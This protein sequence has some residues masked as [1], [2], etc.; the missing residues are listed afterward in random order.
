MLPLLIASVLSEKIK[1]RYTYKAQFTVSFRSME[2]D[3]EDKFS[4]VYERIAAALNKEPKS[5]LIRYKGEIPHRCRTIRQAGVLE[6]T[7]LLVSDAFE[8]GGWKPGVVAKKP[9]IYVYP[10]EPT[11]VKI[12]VQP[13]GEFLAVYP[14]FTDK[15]KNEWLV[16][17]EPGGKLTVDGRKYTSLFWEADTKQFFKPTFEEGFIVESKNA[18]HFLEKKL[19]FMGLTDLEANEFITFW[20]PVLNQNEKSVVS[21]QFNNYDEAAPLEISPKPDSV[22]RIFL[23]IRKAGDNMKIKK[24]SLPRFERKGFTVVEWGGCNI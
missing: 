18:V 4:V 10:T 19:R 12:S 3:T 21:F 1:I 2:F 5:I 6:N 16:H 15:S 8:I 13:K 17:A 23:A 7:V 11:N 14:E 9:V 22:I 20:L 24:Q